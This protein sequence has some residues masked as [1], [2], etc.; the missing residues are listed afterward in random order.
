MLMI[1]KEE[2]ERKVSARKEEI[3]AENSKLTQFRQKVA[4]FV[5]DIKSR[6]IIYKLIKNLPLWEELEHLIEED[7]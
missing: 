7:D 4:S 3:R 6:S 5:N 2:L 1:T